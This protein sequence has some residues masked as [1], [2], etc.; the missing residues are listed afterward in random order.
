M[1]VICITHLPQIA[2]K[3]QSHYFVYKNEEA[4]KT[5]TAIKKLNEI[6]RIRAIAEMLSGKDPGESAIKNAEELLKQ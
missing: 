3:G 6:E 4:E 5:T 2:A 1:Q